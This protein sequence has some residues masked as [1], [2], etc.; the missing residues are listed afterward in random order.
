MIYFACDIRPDISFVVGQLSWYNSDL[1]I[2]YIHTTKSVLWYLTG[3]MLLGLIYERDV[4]YFME[5]YKL[6]GI[7]G[8]ANNNY[9]GNPEDWKSIMNYCFFINR[10]VVI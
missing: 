5:L 6:Y 9:K 4:A 8:Y 2:I 3:T 1:Q 7:F 10:A